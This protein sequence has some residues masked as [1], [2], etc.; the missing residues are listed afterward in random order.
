MLG[1]IVILMNNFFIWINTETDKRGWSNSELARRAGI[2]RAS[3]SNTM[4]GRNSVTWDF[5]AAIAHAL[6]MPVDDVFRMAGLM[7]PIHKSVKLDKLQSIV[8]NLGEDE[9]AIVSA[10]ADFVY[11][12]QQEEKTQG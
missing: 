2:S 5:C 4:N 6:S 11:Q 9:L 1:D 3:I 12:R 8:K 7:R 10:F